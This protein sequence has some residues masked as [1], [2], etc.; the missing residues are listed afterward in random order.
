MYVCM[1]VCIYL[2]IYRSIYLSIYLSIE[3][4]RIVGAGKT[5]GM[6][7]VEGSA[8]VHLARIMSRG[9]WG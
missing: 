9:G 3:I 2:S 1:Y 7:H 8:W 4:Y 6:H 5:G